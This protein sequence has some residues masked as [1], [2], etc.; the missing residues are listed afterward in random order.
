MA[1]YTETLNTNFNYPHIDIY[2]TFTDGVQNGYEVRPHEG[3]I[4]YESDKVNAD[5]EYDPETGTEYPIT[6]YFTIAGMPMN[7]NFDNFK[8]VAISQLEA[9]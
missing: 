3:Y 8:W 1:V 7:Y 4:M 9:N 5:W 2:N 6:R